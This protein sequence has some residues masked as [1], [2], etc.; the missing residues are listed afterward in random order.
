MTLN[1]KKKSTK[2]LRFESLSDNQKKV[3]RGSDCKIQ[4]CGRKQKAI[5][6]GATK[7]W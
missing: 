4:L 1:F 7:N 2:M 5:M 6:I 3:L